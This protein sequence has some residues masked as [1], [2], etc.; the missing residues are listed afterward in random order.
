VFK[1]IPRYNITVYNIYDD[2][3][4]PPDFLPSSLSFGSAVNAIALV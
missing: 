3:L 2:P 1:G 4:L